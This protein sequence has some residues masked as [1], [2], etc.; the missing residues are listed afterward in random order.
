M[1]SKL[2]EVK[3]GIWY[4]LHIQGQAA[5]RIISYTYSSQKI[6]SNLCG[7]P[8][9]ISRALLPAAFNIYNYIADFWSVCCYACCADRYNHKKTK[10]CLLPFPVPFQDWNQPLQPQT[11]PL[12]TLSLA[13][14]SYPVDCPPGL[15]C[16]EMCHISPSSSQPQWPKKRLLSD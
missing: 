12:S 10:N 16:E 5:P 3:Y 8:W 9:L 6:S 4:R 11:Q 7:T 2:V 15:S 13:H 14:H 1:K